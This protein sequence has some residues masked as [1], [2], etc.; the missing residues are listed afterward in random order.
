MKNLIEKIKTWISKIG[1]KFRTPVFK[2]DNSGNVLWT[3]TGTTTVTLPVSNSIA[4]VANP[5]YIVNGGIPLITS[6]GGGGGGYGGG[7]Y[8]GFS[9]NYVPP[10]HIITF[11]GNNGTIVTLNKDGTVTWAQDITVDEAAE[12]FGKSL[13]LGAEVAVGIT[14]GVKC[15]MRDSVFNDLI[16]LAKEKGSLN[17]EELTYL[18]QAS[19][20]VE[21]LKGAKE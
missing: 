7:G 5:Q 16:Q 11:S 21:K 4:P 14:A 20:I 17:A 6:A 3:T 2:L 9:F 19:K 12:A 13:S 8:G 15:R 1:D 18:L 10:P